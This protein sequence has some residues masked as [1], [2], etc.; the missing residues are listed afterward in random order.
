MTHIRCIRAHVC[1]SPWILEQFNNTIMR[2]PVCFAAVTCSVAEANETDRCWV[3]WEFRWNIWAQFGKIT[4]EK[5]SD[6]KE[7]IKCISHP[8]VILSDEPCLCNPPWLHWNFHRF[9]WEQ[10]PSR[11]PAEEFLK[12]RYTGSTSCWFLCY[13]PAD[14]SLGKSDIYESNDDKGS[15][16]G[17]A[18]PARGRN[19]GFQ[20]ITGHTQQSPRHTHLRVM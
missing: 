9:R 6:K 14:G 5:V 4:I 11:L 18:I 12:H 15:W 13:V 1:L 19:T 20:S 10:V 7:T 3:C 2:I 16:G 8:D 17:L